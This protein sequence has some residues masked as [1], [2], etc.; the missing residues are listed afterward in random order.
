MRDPK[1][2]DKFCEMFKSYWHIVCNLQVISK[3]T[4]TMVL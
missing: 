1:R 2:I 4:M 3:H